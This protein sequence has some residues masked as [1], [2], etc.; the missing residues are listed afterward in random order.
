[1]QALIGVPMA[2]DF[3]GRTLAACEFPEGPPSMRMIRSQWARYPLAGGSVYLHRADA[4]D[5]W[6]LVTIFYPGET[7]QWDWRIDSTMPVTGF[8]CVR[9]SSPRTDGSTCSSGC[10]KSTPCSSMAATTRASRW[11]CRPIR[12]VYNR[13]NCNK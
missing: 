13:S 12:S 5:S 2:A 3:F 10:L 7:L 1:M 4:A 9:I 8:R 11:I 6:R